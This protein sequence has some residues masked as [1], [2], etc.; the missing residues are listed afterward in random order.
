MKTYIAFVAFALFALSSAFAQDVDVSLTTAGSTIT[1]TYHFD[2]DYS[3]APNN[4]WNSQVLTIRWA[5]DGLGNNPV[6]I[7]NF[8]DVSDFDY[9]LDGSPIADVPGS[10]TYY[11]QKFVGNITF[12]TISVTL[13]TVMAVFT[14]DYT[15]SD[16]TP[17]FELVTD[18]DLP[19]TVANGEATITA[20]AILPTNR[21]RAFINGNTFPVEWLKFEAKPI[22]SSDVELDW[23]TAREVNNSH[24]VVERS[25]DGT[26]YEATGKVNGAGT[27]E[28]VQK[29]TFIDKNVG[30][31]VL[32]YRLKQVDL[33]GAYDYSEVVEVDF[34]KFPSLRGVN[35]EIYPSPTTDMVNIEAI[36]KLE[37]DFE[38]RITDLTGRIVYEGKLDVA[39]RKSKINVSKLSEGIYYVSLADVRT[40]VVYALGK[41]VK[42]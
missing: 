12:K 39:T 8:L 31:S 7:S 25:I 6:S 30:A 26:L 23:A 11:Y 28:E 5:A 20:A 33:N 34:S 17:N 27:I 15:S 35:F 2:G 21:F 14:F 24:F 37:K 29:Y 16:G 22:N 9:A 4:I 36:G 13:G 19:G 40:N 32:Y 1:V 10:A 38:L 18:P 42:E 3:V 41:F